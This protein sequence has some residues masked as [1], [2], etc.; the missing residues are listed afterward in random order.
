VK[1]R[2]LI[3]A[4]AALLSLSAAACGGDD[5][6]P[7]GGGGGEA[8]ES[9]DITLLQGVKGDEFYI[10]MACGAQEAADELNVN[11]TV[12]GPDE[13]DPSQQIPILN[14]IIAEQ[15]DALLI[16]PTDTKAL[17]APMQQA[18]DAGIT[19]V[20][21]DT[22]VEQEDISVSKIATD[23]VEGGRVAARALAELIGGE[24]AVLVVNVKPGI[25][26]TDQRQQGFEEEIEKSANVEYL[27]TEFS[28]NEPARAASIVS[29]TLAAERDLKGIFGTNLFSA[30]GSATGLRN[31]G[32]QERVSIV[33]FDAGPAQVE[34]LKEDL[35]QALVA[36]KP[37]DIGRFGIEQAVKALKDEEVEPEIKTDLVT[38]TQDNVDDPEIAN[39]VLYKADC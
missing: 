5:G 17:I 12:Q 15:P 8:E 6:E 37:A 4:L 29:A 24:G 9:Y 26:T 18:K 28:N 39:E 32:A 19:V 13:F 1:K 7:A 3:V 30:E 36:Q 11:L 25:S 14:G 27:G 23:N 33:G 20:E 35:V 10:T 31:A 2:F 38:V 34:Q 16:A 22:T 21:V